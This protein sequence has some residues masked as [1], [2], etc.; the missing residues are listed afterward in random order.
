MKGFL[1]S[2]FLTTNYFAR[3]LEG[4]S[5]PFKSVSVENRFSQRQICKSRLIKSNMFGNCDRLMLIRVIFFALTISISS[6]SA[7][8]SDVVQLPV[9]IFI[10]GLS[11][12]SEPW[13][14]RCGNQSTNEHHAYLRNGEQDGWSINKNVGYSCDALWGNQFAYWKVYQPG[15]DSG[16]AIVFWLARDDGFYRSVDKSTWTREK[17]WEHE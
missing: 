7:R 17:E 14:L 5:A 1:E 12:N 10:N 15:E 13:E 4:F 6:S 9:L 11:H 2:I 16:K 8:F 3:S